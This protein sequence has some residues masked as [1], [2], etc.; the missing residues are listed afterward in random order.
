[1]LFFLVNRACKLPHCLKENSLASRVFQ[2]VC[3]VYSRDEKQ[4]QL[5]IEQK[6]VIIE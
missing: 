4:K 1:M 3:K 2:G 6:Q 5:I